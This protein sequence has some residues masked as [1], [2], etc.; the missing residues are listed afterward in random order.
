M[1]GPST[2]YKMKWLL[3]LVWSPRVTY[4]SLSLSNLKAT[5][6]GLGHT[7][8][9]T[10][11]TDTQD[12]STERS[13]TNPSAQVNCQTHRRHLNTTPSFGDLTVSASRSTYA[14]S[15]I[16]VQ[17]YIR[18]GPECPA[19]FG[20]G[21]GSAVREDCGGLNPLSGPR[22]RT[23]RNSKTTPTTGSPEAVLCDVSTSELSQQQHLWEWSH[24]TPIGKSFDCLDL[25]IRR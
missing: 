16:T 7:R 10:S 1:A 13:V 3:L 11:S 23:I 4:G 15:D 5:V 20:R 6:C 14:P 8:L 12:S 17:Y 19:S 25:D 9:E 18:D 21:G 2:E 24:P 22:K